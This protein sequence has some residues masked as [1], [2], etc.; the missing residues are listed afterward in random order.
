MFRL[1]KADTD[2]ALGVETEDDLDMAEADNEVLHKAEECCQGEVVCDPREARGDFAR[3][4][5]DSHS[6]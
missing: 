1:L 3:C 4:A 6:R 2:K 5:G